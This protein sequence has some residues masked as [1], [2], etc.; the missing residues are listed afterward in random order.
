MIILHKTFIGCE[1]LKKI[2]L[3]IQ[4]TIL[5]FVNII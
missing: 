3:I 5:N 2:N 4:K 1:N